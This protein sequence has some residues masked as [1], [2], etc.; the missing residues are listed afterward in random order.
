M[1][2]ALCFWT[3]VFIFLD[4]DF[5]ICK[6]RIMV[7][8][9]HRVEKINANDHKLSGI[10]DPCD[11]SHIYCKVSPYSKVTRTHAARPSRK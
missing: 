1:L 8:P 2:L 5:L 3:V 10:K 4:F 6:L 11:I 7:D 9:S